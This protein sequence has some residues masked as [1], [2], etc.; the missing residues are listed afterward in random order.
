VIFNPIGQYAVDVTFLH[1]EVKIDF[2]HYP[3]MFEEFRNDIKKAN[4]L[5][6]EV[7]QKDKS[8][9]RSTVS[10]LTALMFPVNMAGQKF[11]ETLQKLPEMTYEEARFDP[12]GRYRRETRADA[13]E[14]NLSRQERFAAE[15]A[16]GAASTIIGFVSDIFKWQEIKSIKSD[17][18]KLEKSQQATHDRV[19][20]LM[21]T[22]LTQ[23]Q[24]LT[25]HSDWIKKNRDRLQT[26]IAADQAKVFTQLH[27]FGGIIQREVD[28][29]ADTVK[30]AHLG[31]LNP[32]QI[33]LTQLNE[34][35]AFIREM[36]ESHQLESPVHSVADLFTMP[37]SY[38]YNLQ[39]TQLEFIIHVPM[40]QPGQI[41]DMYE[42]VPFSMTMTND[43]H[44]VAVPRPGPHNVLAYNKHKEF[45]TLA[46]AELQAC[47]LL[48]KVHY[49]ARR[50]VL[51]TDWSKTCLSSLFARN[52]EAATRYCDFHI[53]P[54][55]ER[56]FK[57]QGSD[58]LIY[59]NREIV[60][61]RICGN[62]HDQVQIREGSIVSV[63][64]GCRLK[65]E[66]HQIYGEVGINR[67]FEAP[68]IFE[69]TWDAQRILRNHSGLSLSQAIEA[70]EHEA[71]MYSFE[72]EDLLQQ[73]DL[74]RLE[75]ELEKAQNETL[76]LS[77]TV[78]NPFGLMHWMLAI[79][80]CVVT[81]VSTIL[82]IGFLRW[83]NQRRLQ[84]QPSAPVAPPIHY[85][86][87]APPALNFI[88]A[89]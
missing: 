75:K 8:L 83:Y 65:L 77:S 87:P 81:F 84:H 85:Q 49:C 51:R 11:S 32:D 27:T 70:M 62:R 56:V 48:K 63:P 42:Y 1:L 67:G 52:Q 71:G 72:T 61:E 58:F 12:A 73:M 44:R 80:S 41:L 34:M 25:Q 82:L 64:Q 31:K 74:Q 14:E 16:F 36:E 53:Q 5:A 28:T 18:W 59:T 17:L 4:D 23:G 60:T 26:L 66:S 35:L 19:K 88:S 21:Q 54:A 33:S 15:L 78:N 79:I 6:Q 57:L 9:R 69:W 10:G 40:T 24:L 13:Q 86:P 68:H 50:Q 45:Q 55:D 30:M 3:T 43:R 46:T 76:Q 38:M 29:F 2:G 47:F 22:T 20:M 7:G 39:E 89:R 37:L